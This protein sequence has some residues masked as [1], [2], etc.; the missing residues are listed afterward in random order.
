MTDYYT[1]LAGATKP[2]PC[3]ECHGNPRTESCFCE[4]QQ[5]CCHGTGQ[6]PLIP[7]LRVP[8]GVIRKEYHTNGGISHDAKGCPG[9]TVKQDSE[10]EWVLREWLNKNHWQWMITILFSNTGFFAQVEKTGRFGMFIG[11]AALAQA[12]CKALGV[13]VEA[14]K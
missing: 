12:L 3:T 13:E 10:A 1:I 4:E 14:G 2:C 9:Y 8:C 7:E 5:L 6:V 11:D